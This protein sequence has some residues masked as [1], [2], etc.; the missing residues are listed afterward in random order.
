MVMKMT[1]Q[2][3][4]IVIGEGN[5][6]FE[7]ILKIFKENNIDSNLYYIELN[8]FKQSF[9]NWISN[10][11]CVSCENNGKNR[12]TC[13]Q[14]C[15][16]VF[17]HRY[18]NKLKPKYCEK[19]KNY[20]YQM[21]NFCNKCG[22]ERKENIKVVIKEFDL[23]ESTKGK[24]FEIKIGDFGCYFYDKLTNQD[25]SIKSVV[26]LLNMWNPEKDKEFY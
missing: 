15:C 19:C 26:N 13:M 18:R 23:T 16:S 6:V 14:Y 8:N 25:L 1:N 17:F 12:G 22:S 2:N 7:D 11:I 24:R 5:K 10:N 20:M 9:I 4:D 3:K 21:H